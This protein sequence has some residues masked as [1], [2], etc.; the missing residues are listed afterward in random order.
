MRKRTSHLLLQNLH[1]FQ[2][3]KI[4][5]SATTSEKIAFFEIS[6]EL[7]KWHFRRV[8]MTTLAG[9]IIMDSYFFSTIITFDL[10]H[11]KIRIRMSQF[12]S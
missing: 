5:I 6:Q 11:S 8:N 1:F 7:N 2:R 9:A 12:V 3:I 4:T 10:N